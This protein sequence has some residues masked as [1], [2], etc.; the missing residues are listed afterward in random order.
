MRAP[1]DRYPRSNV[2]LLEKHGSEVSRHP[3]AHVGSGIP[4]KVTCVHPNSRAEF[5]EVR[6]RRGPI[7][8]ASGHTVGATF[9]IL[10]HD[11]HLPPPIDSRSR[12]TRLALE[13]LET[14]SGEDNSRIEARSL[15]SAAA[16]R[17]EADRVYA[18]PE[19]ILQSAPPKP[20]LIARLAGSVDWKRRTDSGAARKQPRAFQRDPEVRPDNIR[21]AQRQRA[22]SPPRQRY[23]QRG[24]SSLF[25]GIG[26]ALGF[27]RN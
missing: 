4:W 23:E 27:S 5:H 25:A 21:N 16:S 6:H 8:S 14:Q 18:Q 24:L 2:D 20:S 3:H 17:A 7:V 9:V 22:V 13:S 19:E 11:I 15:P 26:H 10:S 1:E 12:R